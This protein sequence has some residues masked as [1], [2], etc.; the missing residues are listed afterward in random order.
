MNATETMTARLLPLLDAASEAAG[1]LNVA[2]TE[3]VKAKLAPGGNIDN[4][5]LEREQH[6]AHGL[7]WITTYVEGIRQMTVFSV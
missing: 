6:I 7:A 5:V 3:A 4:A 1:T 2:A